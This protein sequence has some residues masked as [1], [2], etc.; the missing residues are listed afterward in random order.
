MGSQSAY[1]TFALGHRVSALLAEPFS[2]Y[3]LS[4]R[5]LRRVG[6][7][8]AK[9]AYYIDTRSL[10]VRLDQVVGPGNWS[11][12]VDK[13]EDLGDRIAVVSSLIIGSVIRCGEGE[14]LKTRTKTKKDGPTEIVPN[15]HVFMQAG[16]QA[17]KRAAVEFGVGAYLYKLSDVNTIEDVNTYG[18]PVDSSIDLTKLP[19]WARPTPGQLLIAREMAYLL[20]IPESCLTN[21]S[22]DSDKKSAIETIKEA[23]LEFFNV[24][25][26]DT[27]FEVDDYMYLAGV[28][29]RIHDGMVYDNQ[30]LS[31]N[32][33]KEWLNKCFPKQRSL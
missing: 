33:A 4:K 14:S 28:I 11:E 25:L 6:S 17:R 20:G 13:I 21:P 1:P 16:P 27:S 18:N 2:S 15:E 32:S 9:M 3:E 12:R 10:S 19:A 24:T 7:S 8:K 23:F 5:V 26:P 31:L 29:A 30:I 22:A